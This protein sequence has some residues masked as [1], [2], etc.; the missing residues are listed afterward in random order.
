MLRSVVKC[1][2]AIEHF[3]SVYI[4]HLNTRRIGEFETVMQSLDSGLHNFREF[5]LTPRV[6]RWGFV[7]TV[8]VF[9]CFYKIILDQRTEILIKQTNVTMRQLSTFLPNKKRPRLKESPIWQRQTK[10]YFPG[11]FYEFLSFLF[12]N[13]AQPHQLYISRFAPRKWGPLESSAPSPLLPRK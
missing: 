1:N 9:Y 6:L 12:R 5:S 3:F 2:W 8:K 10:K 11:C 13:S 7:N 4:A